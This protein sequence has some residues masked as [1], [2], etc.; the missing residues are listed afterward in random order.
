MWSAHDDTHH[1][2]RRYTPSLLRKNL[3]SAGFIVDY[4]SY[5]NMTL[6]IPAAIMRFL[7]RGGESALDMP[8]VIDTLFHMII[9][10]ESSVMRAVP[11]PWGISLVAVA[12][13]KNSE[14]D[15]SDHRQT[16]V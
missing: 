8:R 13:K 3:E 5:W 11:L 14:K 10:A 7:G 6:F 16:T 12:R 2:F 9:R 1:H 4:L 15:R